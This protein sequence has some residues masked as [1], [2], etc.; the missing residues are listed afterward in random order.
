LIL[1]N[2]YPGVTGV[3]VEELYTLD[4]ESF[5]ALKYYTQIFIFIINFIYKIK[6]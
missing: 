4:Q 6:I 5:N 3:Q 2:K 1:F